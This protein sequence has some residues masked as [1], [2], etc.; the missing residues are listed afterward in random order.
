MDGITDAMV[1]ICGR[2][3]AHGA[4]RPCQYNPAAIAAQMPGDDPGPKRLQFMPKSPG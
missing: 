3:T 2:T 1:A 4:H